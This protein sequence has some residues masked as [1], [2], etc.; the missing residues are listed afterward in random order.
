MKV[1]RYS[2]L[3]A[4]AMFAAACGDKVTVAGPT[5]VTLTS[6]TTTT[7]TPVVPGK[8]NSISVA[9][10]AV[11]LAVGQ[12]VTLVA[13]VNADAGVATT[14]T[15]STSDATKVTVSTAG[16]VTAVAA[17]PGVAICA[18]STVNV[19]V[20]GCGSVVVTA[21]TAVTPATVTI[22]G[23]FGT[24]LTAPITPTSVRGVVTVQANVDPGTQ[25]VTKVYLR[26]GTTV[27][28]SQILTAAQSAALRYASENAGATTAEVDQAEVSS[29]ILL[30]V[31]TAAYN[32]TTGAVSFLNSA[33]QAL[34]VQLFT[35]GVT[36]AASTATYSTSLTLDNLDIVLGSWTWP[37]GSVI[38]NDAAG[39]SWRSFKGG[40]ASLTI[41]PVLYTG[42]TVN[43]LTASY[44]YFSNSLAWGATS[45]AATTT[46]AGY[47]NVALAAVSSCTILPT[48]AD[49]AQVKTSTTAPATFTFGLY[50]REMLRGT[51]NAN[52][53]TPPA[54]TVNLGYTD[55]SSSSGITL[56]APA[57]ASLAVRID[58]RGP[59]APTIIGP[60]NRGGIVGD[61]TILQTTALTSTIG[62]RPAVTLVRTDSGKLI[63][64]VT[65]ADS[66]V[67][68]GAT[69]TDLRGVTFKTF[70][71][72]G[73]ATA[74]TDTS[75]AT[76]EVT[77]GDLSGLT[78]GMNYGIQ[79]VTYDALGNPS[80]DYATGAV[81][82][83]A[84]RTRG[85]VN[86]G[87]S[88][89]Q[90]RMIVDN[91]A[92][93]SAWA[94]IAN[95][96]W[97]AA[98]TAT[99]ASFAAGAMNYFFTNTE[100]NA[101]TD[102]V[103]ACGYQNVSNTMTAAEYIGG[104]SGTACAR[105]V[106]GT[107]TGTNRSIM[108]ATK[109][110]NQFASAAATPAGF[111]ATPGQMVISQQHYD[112]A[113][114][115]GNRITRVVLYDDGVPTASAA[116]IAT[117]LLGD[118]P[119]VASFLNDGMSVANYA[120]EFMHNTLLAQS[121]HVT[122]HVGTVL[123]PGLSATP[124]V[125]IF[126]GPLTSTT[127]A[128]S[129]SPYTKFLNQNV[130]ISAP[131]FQY[132]SVVGAGAVVNG[133]P[134]LVADALL[135]S[136]VGYRVFAQDHAGNRTVG[137]VPVAPTI[138]NLFNTA[139]L[140]G[141]GLSP[142]GGASGAVTSMVLDP[143]YTYSTNY[144]GSA[145]AVTGGAVLSSSVRLKVTYY[146]RHDQTSAFFNGQVSA[147]GWKYC[148]GR[149]ETLGGTPIMNGVSV[150]GEGSIP[151]ATTAPTVSLYLPVRAGL[152]GGASGNTVQWYA[153]ATELS[154]VTVVGTPKNNCGDL[155]TKT[156]TVTVTPTERT[157]QNWTSG[158]AIW[159]IKHSNGF[160][161]FLPMGI[162]YNK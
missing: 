39:Y 36:T 154:S 103:L 94:G 10:A 125:P 45:G 43:S 121:T 30:S 116:T 113:G 110:L 2:A 128:I 25:V 160:A 127:D 152:T 95:G 158:A 74:T 4:V 40:N 89:A 101:G 79:V 9:P 115:I 53:T 69:A 49:T 126:R 105:R 159:V 22:A 44:V 150:M 31:N 124:G 72:G 3:A 7:T 137:S 13:A 8:V 42:K 37:T 14:H 11:T 156:F 59:A 77:S 111:G 97:S 28:D 56:T 134:S 133:T 64:A 47:C 67:S 142:I 82:A 139:A 81:V 15:W 75:L 106:A 99:T 80:T 130:A 123:M 60:K 109:Q 58:N 135:A 138:S 93:V 92:P 114:N 12:A 100:A 102:S 151:Q 84:I 20:K 85:F 18:T 24:S 48:T 86:T 21:A 88:A 34:S 66:G 5:A 33:S 55:G 1:L 27:V 46:S 65:D 146:Q 29:T 87:V 148:T 161:S 136:S 51:S 131:A 62:I 19:G 108:T 38:A 147:T 153:D 73:G 76:T 61:A 16:L 32:A 71:N 155:I 96:D 70:R 35:S 50:D 52:V 122:S 26:L 119:S 112:A 90:W 143:N 132:L 104:G 6:T 117:V 145:S 140:T 162:G 63:S 120:V 107:S 98:D 141:A 23:V 91:T 78:E 157:Y 17:T 144:A 41:T 54:P 129:T 149:T 57:G 68:F 83:G 118:T